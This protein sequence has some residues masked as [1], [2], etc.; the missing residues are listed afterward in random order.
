MAE[1][2]AH[3]TKCGTVGRDA[4]Q[5]EIENLGSADEGSQSRPGMLMETGL[6][7]L[8]RDTDIW[9]DTKAEAIVSTILTKWMDEIKAKTSKDPHWLQKPKDPP[10]R[11]LKC[12]NFVAVVDVMEAW[13]KNDRVDDKWHEYRKLAYELAIRGYDTPAMMDGCRVEEFSFVKGDKLQE[14]SCKEQF[15]RPARSG[16]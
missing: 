1:D 2:D 11:G 15:W 4:G 7:W 13:L 6:P 5:E 10:M 9:I 12:R 8:L 16:R 14:G 3:P